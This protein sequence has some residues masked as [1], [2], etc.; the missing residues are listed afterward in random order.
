MSNLWADP[1]FVRDELEAS[2]ELTSIV[3]PDC[4]KRSFNSNDVREGYCGNCHAYTRITEPELR[5]LHG[6]R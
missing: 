1:D 5:S 2:N 6:D 3:C 4:G